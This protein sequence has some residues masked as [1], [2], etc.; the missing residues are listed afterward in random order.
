MGILKT[1]TESPSWL[2]FVISSAVVAAEIVA[3]LCVWFV[4]KRRHE[5]MKKNLGLGAPP[6]ANGGGGGRSP[7]EG[8]DTGGQAAYH[9]DEEYQKDALSQSTIQFY[10]SVFAA[11]AGFALVIAMAVMAIVHN[12][13]EIALG[14]LPGVVINIV[15][16][17]FFKQAKDT[18]DLAAAMYNQNVHRSNVFDSREIAAAI[19]DGKMRSVVMATL[20]LNLASSDSKP[21]EQIQALLKCIGESQPGAQE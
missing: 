20:A 17:L 13:A 3:V 18:R 5:F 1:F 21:A 2:C 11:A 14:T 6:A 16:A 7:E 8:A 19:E 9:F 15:S 12:D 4:H 10:L